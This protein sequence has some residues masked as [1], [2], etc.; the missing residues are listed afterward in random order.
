[1]MPAEG[2]ACP[3]ADDERY[4]WAGGTPD[5]VFLALLVLT[6]IV[7]QETSFKLVI[8]DKGDWYEW[9]ELAVDRTPQ[10]WRI[11]RIELPAI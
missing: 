3:G 2:G 1:M 9:T 5:G 4:L 8:D 10:G 6:G 11:V 7:A